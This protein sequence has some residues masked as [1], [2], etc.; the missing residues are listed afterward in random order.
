MRRRRV[1]CFLLAGIGVLYAV[2][3]PWYRASG[4]PPVVV[5]GL[6]DWVLV[7]FVC[8]VGVAV[9]NAAAWLLTDVRDSE[10]EDAR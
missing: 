1:R 8:Y 6:P 5:L 4:A 9:M 2:S 7:A 3:V 10:E